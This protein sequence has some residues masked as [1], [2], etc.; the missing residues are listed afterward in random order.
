MRIAIVGAGINDWGGVSPLTPDYVNPEA[1][2]PHLE[3]L[4]RETAAAGINRYMQGGM[5]AFGSYKD[6]KKPLDTYKAT[7]DMVDSSY[8]LPKDLAPDIYNHVVE[9]PS[10]K[11]DAAEDIFYWEKIDFGQ[12]PVIRV[13]HVSLF[14]EGRRR[15]EWPTGIFGNVA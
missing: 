5:K 12:G 15:P 11:M 1:P 4:A 9:Y 2:W 10:G 13:N 8:Y 14:P 6:R 7:R 3:R